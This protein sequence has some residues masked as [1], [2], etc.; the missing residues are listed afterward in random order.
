MSDLLNA[1]VRARLTL[2]VSGGTGSGKTTLLNALSNAISHKE[3]LIT[4]E[5]AAELR[6]QQPHVGRL[7]TRP[8][9]IEGRGEIRQRELVKNAL[10]MRPDRIMIGEVR[11]E[12]AFDMLQA[13]N[14][15]HE[16]SMTTIHAN[17][18][19]DALARLTQMVGM[20]G[21]NMTETSIRTQIASA[22]SLIIQLQ[23]F[24]DGRRRIVSLTEITGIERDVIQ[25]QEIFKFTRMGTAPDGQ[26][27]GDF[28]ATGLRP[29]FMSELAIRGYS[30]PSDFFDPGQPL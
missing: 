1:A 26:V 2:V 6:L 23:R 12:E 10:R 21:L 5:D 29:T 24:S 11:G 14:T 28:R 4:I 30:F 17:S 9:N 16:G 19:R 25:M 7:E 13:M 20:A 22:V 15:G 3:R 27:R 8:P 18:A